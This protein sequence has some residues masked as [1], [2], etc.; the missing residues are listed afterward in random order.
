MTHKNEGIGS[1]IEQMNQKRAGITH[2]QFHAFVESNA[3]LRN[4]VE[5]LI[6]LVERQD[7]ERIAM[8]TLLEAK[9]ISGFDQGWAVGEKV[10][11]ANGSKKAK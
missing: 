11:F 7:R 3:A 10:G 6:V 9:W 5:S 2:D 8:A 1:S 4:R